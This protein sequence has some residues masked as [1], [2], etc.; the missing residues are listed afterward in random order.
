MP[1][2]GTKRNRTTMPAPRAGQ[3][4]VPH[5]IVDA[6]PQVSAVVVGDL[7]LDAWH[8]GG[9]DRMASE[10]PV[11]VVA[12]HHTSYAPGGAANTAA[13]LAALGGQVEVI[14]V[15]G[16]DHSARRLA[17]ALTNCGVSTHLVPDENRPTTVK[18]RVCS[19]GQVLARYDDEDRTPVS[20]PVESALIEQIQR[21]G[22]GAEMLIVCDYA[23]GVCTERVRA[24]IAAICGAHGPRLVVD[25]RRLDLWAPLRPYA[26]LPNIAEAATLL[27]RPVTGD[28]VDFLTAY[29]TEICDRA[30]ADLVVTTI[31][32]QG[33]L[34]HR[35]GRP[36]HRT[37]ASPAPD[38]RASG[39]GDTYTATFALALAAGADPPGAADL[40]QAAAN[41]VVRRDGTALCTCDDLLRAVATP[42]GAVLSPH[43]LLDRIRQH[44]VA[45]ARIAFTNGCFDVLHRGHVTYLRQAA[46]LADLLVVALNSDESV[47]RLKGPGRPINRLDDRAA[48]LAALDC[49]DHVTVFDEDT[50][51]RLLRLIRPDV[52]VK[53][54]D[55]SL[56]MLP[57]AALVAELGGEVHLVDYI[58]GR[59]T[60]DIVERI[61]SSEAARP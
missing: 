36:I 51:E 41:V 48:V 61:K 2:H 21:L 38:Q 53:G 34:V 12:V 22:P 58:A 45:G 54:G 26:V 55:Y 25:A 27:G 10:A 3:D 37:H 39:A 11:P 40:A 30:G 5:P 24:A 18:H 17:D 60:T 6:F 9:A 59:S 4:R 57:E 35:K 23:I 16:A 20:G 31:D 56:L 29:S 42:Q 15:V 52:Y 44:R 28:R 7:L 19:S 32:G 1:A 49:V 14:G 50:P 46:A 13:N 43:D 8:M 33:S 47:A